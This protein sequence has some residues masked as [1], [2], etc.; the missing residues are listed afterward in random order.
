MHSLKIPFPWQALIW[1]KIWYAYDSG[2]LPHALL[3]TGIQ[4]LGKLAF[5]QALAK[6]LLCLNPNNEESSL[7]KAKHRAD[8]CLTPRSNKRRYFAENLRFCDHCKSCRLFHTGAHPDYYY[9]P[10]EGSNPTISIDTI[11]NLSQWLQK[12]ARH[13]FTTS[14]YTKVVLIQSAEN[15]QTAA[16]NAL[17]KSLEEPCATTLFILIS[18]QSQQL[19]TTIHSRCQIIRFAPP[20]FMEAKDWVQKKIPV[21]LDNNPSTDFLAIALHL[22]SGAPLQAVKL[23]DT[24][25]IMH[26]TQ[27]IQSLYA[28]CLKQKNP[29]EV[30][31]FWL[32]LP[33][34]R[35][36]YYLLFTISDLIKWKQGITTAPINH[37]TFSTLLK[38]I[39]ATVSI[40]FLYQYLDL[41]QE[42]HHHLITHTLNPLLSLERLSYRWLQ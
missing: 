39:A 1:H 22:A 2:K 5:A 38:S 34:E 17:L 40:T 35:L 25:A 29:S 37:K 10:S 16:A 14:H 13:P 21:V 18:P 27:F 23:L 31:A 36:L 11:R 33:I 8:P 26:Y 4:G 12:T 28:L 24:E 6:T 42:T 15:L 30:A 9:L 20:D 32:S 3:F 7:L 41:V 19:V